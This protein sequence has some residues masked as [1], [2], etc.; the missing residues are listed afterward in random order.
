MGEIHLFGWKV[1][2]ILTSSPT[3]L[4]EADRFVDRQSFITSPLLFRI[5]L[6]FHRKERKS[7]FDCPLIP[8]ETA[9]IN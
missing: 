3:L 4:S 5:S 7:Y 2:H 9:R 8:V 6:L 1:R